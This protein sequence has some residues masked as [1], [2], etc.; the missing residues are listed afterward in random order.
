MRCSARRLVN[1]GRT[2]TSNIPN[3]CRA[4]LLLVLP[5]TFIHMSHGQGVSQNLW[6]ETP[7]IYSNRL[8]EIS[9]ASVYLKLEVSIFFH[10]FLLYW[11]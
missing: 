10:I 11:S 2:A 7:L 9:G 1:R 6:Q 8:S 5:Q 3:A 4:V